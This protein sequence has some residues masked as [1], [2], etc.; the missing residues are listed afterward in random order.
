MEVAIYQASLTVE[1]RRTRLTKAIAKQFPVHH[2]YD[3]DRS[4]KV[5]AG[6]SVPSALCKVQASTLV[7]DTGGW[8]ILIRDD[9]AGLLWTRP[10]PCSPRLSDPQTDK[11]WDD[12]V[13]IPTVIL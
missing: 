6:H 8:L 13:K 9:V 4:A 1:G 10:A 2:W 11:A 5:S 7:R 3:G 12:L